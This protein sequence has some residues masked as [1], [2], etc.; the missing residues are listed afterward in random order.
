M[1][2]ATSHV[3][4]CL[5]NVCPGSTCANARVLAACAARTGNEQHALR[6]PRHRTCPHPETVSDL[7]GVHEA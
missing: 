6:L 5:R 7:S 4:E 1:D 3:L 2:A